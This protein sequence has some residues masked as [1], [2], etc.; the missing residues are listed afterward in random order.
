MPQWPLADV[1]DDSGTWQCSCA[2]PEDGARSPAAALKKAVFASPDDIIISG[3]MAR[4]ELSK[5]AELM[6]H[7][8][9]RP[10]IHMAWP[11]WAEERLPPPMSLIHGID[12]AFL[13]ASA[14]INRSACKSRRGALYASEN[15]P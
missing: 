9:V 13:K 3:D 15:Y 11:P 1:P 12:F 7:H 14:A 10:L 5:R 2:D 6:L 8:L 4:I